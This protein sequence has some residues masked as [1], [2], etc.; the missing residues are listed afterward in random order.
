MYLYKWDYVRNYFM[1]INVRARDISN[2]FMI[3]LY[4]KTTFIARLF[5]S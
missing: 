2:K 1:V 4:S 3:D 5:S